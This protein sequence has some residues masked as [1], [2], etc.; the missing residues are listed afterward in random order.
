M[1][2]FLGKILVYIEGKILNKN[3]IIKPLQNF[4]MIRNIS[5]LWQM[6]CFIKITFSNKNS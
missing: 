6:A 1:F 2:L 4:N 3:I 5:E